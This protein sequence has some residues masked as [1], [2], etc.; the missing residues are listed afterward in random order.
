VEYLVRRAIGLRGTKAVKYL[1]RAFRD[2][3]PYITR[4]FEDVVGRI[5]RSD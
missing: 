2:A 3:L 1:E 4:I 5:V